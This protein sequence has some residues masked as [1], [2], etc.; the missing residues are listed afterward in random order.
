MVMDN[1][2][3]KKNRMIIA[4]HGDDTLRGVGMRNH[5]IQDEVVHNKF[6]PQIW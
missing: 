3:E 4:S 6:I 5:S 2:L 1:C